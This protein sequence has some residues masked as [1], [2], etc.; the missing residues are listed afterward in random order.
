MSYDKM[1]QEAMRGAMAL[2][3][4]QQVELHKLALRKA[5]AEA[6]EAEVRR[7]TA[8]ILQRHAVRL[9]EVD[10]LPKTGLLS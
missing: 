9:A 1:T 7:D 4:Q 6:E 2:A 10:G 5:E 8:K 3:A